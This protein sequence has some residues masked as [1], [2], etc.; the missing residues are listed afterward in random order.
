MADNSESQSWGDTIRA[1]EHSKK[2]LPWQPREVDPVVKL[3][4]FEVLTDHTLYTLTHLL[5]RTC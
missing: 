5:P 3:G 1:Y 2:A 4:A